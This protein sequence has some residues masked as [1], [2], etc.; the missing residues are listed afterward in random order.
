MTYNIWFSSE[1]FKNIRN[2]SKFTKFQVRE[3]IDKLIVNPFT[4]DKL[5]RELKGLRS[6]HVGDYRVIYEIIEKQKRIII[7]AVDSRKIIYLKKW[8]RKKAG[9]IRLKGKFL[10]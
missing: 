2:L 6:L 3:G 9:K 1:A 5:K 4:G 8:L 10:I 7:Y